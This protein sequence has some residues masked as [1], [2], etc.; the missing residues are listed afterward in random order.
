MILIKL[1]S[2]CGDIIEDKKI[3]KLHPKDSF[4]IYKS[5]NEAFVG[6]ALMDY[7]YGGNR[8]YERSQ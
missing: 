7:I 3:C 6:E 8:Q 2:N 1:C 4:I 5:N